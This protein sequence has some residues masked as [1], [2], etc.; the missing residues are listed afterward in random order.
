MTKNVLIPPWN[1]EL[2][3]QSFISRTEDCRTYPVLLRGLH[4]P[5]MTR[6]LNVIL[7]LSVVWS[8]GWY[9]APVLSLSRSVA[10]IL[11]HNWPDVWYSEIIQLDRTI[12]KLLN[13]DASIFSFFPPSSYLKSRYWISY[14]C[15]LTVSKQHMNKNDIDIENCNIDIHGW[16]WPSLLLQ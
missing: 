14:R 15:P 3:M 11:S 10:S 8:C 1:A 2:C 4:L 5:N 7:C 13:H 9:G 12:G 6:L 16:S